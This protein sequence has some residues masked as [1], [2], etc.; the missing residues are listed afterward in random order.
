MDA[1]PGCRALMSLSTGAEI[2]DIPDRPR[3]DLPV[4]TYNS[5]PSFIRRFLLAPLSAPRLRK[6]VA[7]LRPD[8]AICAMPAPLDLLMATVLRRL[9][10]PVVVVVHDAD[11]HP[12][13]G[14]RVQMLLQR[15]LLNQSAVAVALTGHVAARLRE[16]GLGM[17]GAGAAAGS[18]PRLMRATLPPLSFG[19]APTAPLS[20]GGPL[21]LLFFGRLLPYKGLDLLAETLARDPALGRRLAVRVVGQ[22][23]DDPALAVLARLPAVTVENRWVPEEE[24]GDLIRWTDAIVLPY[25][26]ASQSGVAA[27]AIAARRWVVSTRVG[28]LAEQFRDE[29]LALLCEPDPADLGRTLHRLLDAPPPLPP[30]SVPADEQWRRMARSLMSDLRTALHLPA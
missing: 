30:L 10:V 16:Q 22:G 11:L 1:V 12:G 24:I 19:V 18:V 23:P 20:H 21:R 29:Q 28:G 13:D 6:R 8:L 17:P 15:R 26:E 14:S 3:C 7:A 9:R 27:A 5:T 25:R 2:L 4:R